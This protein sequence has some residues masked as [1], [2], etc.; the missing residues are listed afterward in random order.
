MQTEGVDYAWA[1][2]TITALIAAGKRFACRYV[3]PG[4][5]GKQ[6]DPAEAAALSAA[7]I[8]VVSNAEGAADG[9]LGGWNVGAS[10][11][12]SAHDRA[13]QCGMPPDRP[14]YL[15]A[16]FDVTPAQWPKVAEALRGAA[17]V[18]GPDR[19]GLY[20]GIDAIVWA[21]RDKAARWFWQTYAWSAGR[22][23]AG[24]H[25]E[26]YRNGVTLGGGTVDLNRALVADYGQWTTGDDMGTYP[27]NLG[28]PPNVANDARDYPDVML[29]D[30]HAALVSGKTGWGDSSAHWVIYE[31]LTR[32]EQ[33]IAN[34]EIDYDLLAQKIAALLPTAPTAEEVADAVVEEIAS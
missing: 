32:I 10:W 8:A 31:Q 9:M 28:E 1:R 20:G 25:I 17:S 15:S 6:L 30:I 14:I 26:Q 29:A 21:R 4:S 22:W 18:L 3:G 24:N 11:A 27:P 7:G 13:M 19:V 33:K 34:P 5:T 2:P 12:K 23:A 16:D